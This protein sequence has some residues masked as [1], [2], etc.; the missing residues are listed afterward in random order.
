MTK[1]NESRTAGKV[2]LELAAGV[3]KRHFGGL[4][5]AN[6]ITANRE[7]PV[8][9]RVD[10]QRAIDELLPGFSRS[11]QLGIHVEFVNET[12]TVSHLLAH[13]PSRV[14][15]GPLQYEEVDVGETMA[16]PCVRRSLWLARH[17]KLPFALVVG[18]A[19]H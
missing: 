5:V 12:L 13:Q 7:Y 10:L 19:V 8:P 11:K 3:L 18:P 14:V 1:H 4:S 2:S 17:G 16:V 9:A 6:L 15:I